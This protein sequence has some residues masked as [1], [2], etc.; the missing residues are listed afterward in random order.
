MAVLGQVLA[1]WLYLPS[2]ASLLSRVFCTMLGAGMVSGQCLWYEWIR[3]GK[4][5][6]YQ[7]LLHGWRGLRTTSQCGPRLLGKDLQILPD[8]DVTWLCFFQVVE[9]PHSNVRGKTFKP[10]LL[11][12]RAPSL[13]EKGPGGEIWARGRSREKWGTERCPRRRVPR[14]VEASEVATGR[15]PAGEAPVTLSTGSLPLTQPE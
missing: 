13:S 1:R 6:G 3:L 11:P 14:P 7:H 10:C 12:H 2:S 15:G 5:T 9:I 8:Q 4:R